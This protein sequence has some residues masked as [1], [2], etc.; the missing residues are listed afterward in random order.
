MRKTAGESADGL[1]FLR[2]KQLLLR[3]L[4]LSLSVS[5]LSEVSRNLR[6]ADK[7]PIVI[8]GVNNDACPEAATVVALT[9][10]FRLVMAVSSAVSGS[11][12]RPIE[13]DPPR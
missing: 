8:D 13:P 4:Q 9:P 10:P 3:L 5:A 2:L 7:L 6:K 11:Q 1:H 12:W